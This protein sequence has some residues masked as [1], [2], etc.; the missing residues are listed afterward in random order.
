MQ[1]DPATII[2]AFLALFVVW[3]LRS[4]LGER[5]GLEQK[6]DGGPIPFPISPPPAPAPND[7][8]WA[9][10]AEPGSPVWTG[11][12]EIARAQPG[13]AARPFLDGASSAYEMVV[14]AFSRGD[15]SMLHSL[16]SEEVFGSFAAALAE[17]KQREETLETTLVGFNSTKIVQARVERASGLIAVRFDA[18]FITFTRDRNGAVIEGDPNTPSN[19]VD[20]WTF[21][22]RNDASSPN[23]TL[24]ATSPAQ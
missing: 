10:F 23:W 4:V 16:T 2:F 1:L 12:D 22:R 3:K 17:R 14:Q 20:I 5:T 6:G 8:G 24:V 9:G 18:Q 19:I 7:Q 13:F 15:E 21:A 11:L